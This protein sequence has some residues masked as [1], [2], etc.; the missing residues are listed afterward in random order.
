MPTPLALRTAA[1]LLS[2]GAAFAA[3]PLAAQARYQ[4]EYDQRLARAALYRLAADSSRRT[5]VR[6]GIAS[7]DTIRLR[8]SARVSLRVIHT[9]SAIYSISADTSAVA[10]QAEAPVRAFVGQFGALLPEVIAL[11]TR[12]SRGDATDDAARSTDALVEIARTRAGA[13][14]DALR[15]LDQ[16]IA[17]DG[18]VRAAAVQSLTTLERMR[19]AGNTQATAAA[20]R[21]TLLLPEGQCTPPAGTRLPFTAGVV[22]QSAQLLRTRIALQETLGSLSTREDATSVLDTLRLVQQRADSIAR[23]IDALVDAAYRVERIALHAA[24]A[25]DVIDV[26]SA[27][28]SSSNGLKLALRVA[29]RPEPELGRLATDPA[30]TFTVV[31]VPRRTLRFSFAPALLIAPNAQLP[32]YAARTTGSGSTVRVDRVGT[33]DARSSWGVVFGVTLQ[34]A[35]LR[36]GSGLA[37]WPV[38]LVFNPS[39]EGRAYGLG[40]ALSW[41]QVKVSAGAA[42]IR[43]TVLVGHREGDVLPARDFFITR[44]ALGEPQLYLG[45]TIVDFTKFFQRIV[46]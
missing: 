21:R 39:A 46:Q 43:Q 25:C 22:E 32:I 23:T 36:P 40:S 8:G 35:E 26:G 7:R 5:L 19:G 24:Y 27:R 31:E 42:W 2:T 12:R 29:P 14:V 13:T 37:W 20:L 44:T 1:F 30:T 45:L 16:W 10:S 3:S 33:R 41:N 34:R 38:E 6:D 9:N 18:G 4:L 15:A 11:S 28:V 17:G